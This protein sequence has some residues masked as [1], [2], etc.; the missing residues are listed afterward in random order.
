MLY[1]P[2]GRFMYYTISSWSSST[3]IY[4]SLNLCLFAC[5]ALVLG[6]LFLARVS[7][8]KDS[9]NRISL[10]AF[11]LPSL[12]I[13]TMITGNPCPGCGT[14]RSVALWLQGNCIAS[15]ARHPS[16]PWVGRWLIGQALLRLFILILGSY[17]A[18]LWAADALVSFSTFLAA[19]YL[20]L[21]LT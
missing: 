16:G 8:E 17:A 13:N 11:P 21:F 14:A 10:G 15:H 2:H 12:C 4:Q 9:D 1:E 7:D 6:I 3:R 18:R 19:S 5:L 20:P